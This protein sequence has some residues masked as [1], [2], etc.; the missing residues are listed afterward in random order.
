MQ[1]NLVRLFIA[2]GVFLLMVSW[3][4]ISPRRQTVTRKQRWPINLG[5]A[6]LTWR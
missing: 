4:A 2:L 1:E 5:L 6:F 3:E